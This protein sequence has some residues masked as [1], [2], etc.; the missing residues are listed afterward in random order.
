MA[1][2][3]LF[4]RKPKENILK[5]S[6][7][8]RYLFL[9]YSLALFF[10]G[11]IYWLLILGIRRTWLLAVPLG[12]LIWIGLASSEQFRLYGSDKVTLSVT[13]KYLQIQSV[14]QLALL[15]STG[16]VWFQDIFPIFSDNLK[17]RL[18]S[19]IL[20]MLGFG[21]LLLSLRR[22]RLIRQNK[23]TFYR[24]IKMMQH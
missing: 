13:K 3:R 15:V 16:T 1:E 20:L 2:L 17:A 23:D 4:S 22:I 14:V 6:L 8:N 19:F 5:A 10:F 7:F 18:A 24:Y 12:L 11:N 9:R 21:V